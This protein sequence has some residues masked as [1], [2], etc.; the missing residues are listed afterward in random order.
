MSTAFCVNDATAVKRNKVELER[1]LCSKKVP[2]DR[3]HGSRTILYWRNIVQ[4]S[5][6]AQRSE[7][8]MKGSAL[9]ERKVDG[10]AIAI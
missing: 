2:F 10:K 9:R 1:I 7:S 4:I 5:N 8:L 6:L 3:P